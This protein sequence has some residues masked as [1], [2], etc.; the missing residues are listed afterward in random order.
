MAANLVPSNFITTSSQKPTKTK[1]QVPLIDADGSALPLS[2]IPHGVP[3]KRGFPA[4]QVV[5]HRIVSNKKKRSNQTKSKHMV[6]LDRIVSKYRFYWRVNH[7]KYARGPSVFCGPGR[8]QLPFCEF[9][10]FTYS[11][12]RFKIIGM[13]LFYKNCIFRY[14]ILCM[15][16]VIIIIK[17]L[18]VDL[19]SNETLRWIIRNK[20][21]E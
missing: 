13:V 2:I 19:Q 14:S 15:N 16:F 6:V 20:I 4:V 8:K 5:L 18:C 10:R 3:L 17:L 7:N 12:M 9:A 11:F 1:T 21:Y